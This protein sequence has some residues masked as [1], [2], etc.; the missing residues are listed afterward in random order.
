MRVCEAG[1]G[2]RVESPWHTI[3]TAARYLAVSPEVFVRAAKASGLIPE[4]ERALRR[5]R[6]LAFHVRDLDS[7]G[8]VLHGRVP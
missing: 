5:G 3:A 1:D 6:Q 4:G 8:D 7:L 2:V